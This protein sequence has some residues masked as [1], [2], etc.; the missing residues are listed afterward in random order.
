MLHA[1][2]PSM[3]IRVRVRDRVRVMNNH[4]YIIGIL[5][6]S[7]WSLYPVSHGHLVGILVLRH[8]RRTFR[9]TSKLPRGDQMMLI[10]VF[11]HFL[12]DNLLHHLWHNA[13]QRD[14]PVVV[15]IALLATWDKKGDCLYFSPHFGSPG[16][17]LAH[18]EMFWLHLWY[19]MWSK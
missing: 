11:S 14:G 18:L 9:R 7:T 4:I 17:R 8:M 13:K 15:F 12:V 6:T 2:V 5:G 19:K 3:L 1:D 16:G 10:N